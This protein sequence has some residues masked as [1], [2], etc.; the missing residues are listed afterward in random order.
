MRNRVS[1]VHL[2]HHPPLRDQGD[3]TKDQNVGER[4]QSGN[5]HSHNPVNT[6]NLLN[7][8]EHPRAR[9]KKWPEKHFTFTFSTFNAATVK[10]DLNIEPQ[11]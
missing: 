7:H 6:L 5:A 9:T 8:S 4:N 1:Q 11:L 3:G 2:P 10:F